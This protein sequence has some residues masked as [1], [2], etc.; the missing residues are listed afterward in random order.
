MR[1]KKF[2]FYKQNFNLICKKFDLIEQVKETIIEI[3][4]NTK[5]VYS[6]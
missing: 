4:Y 3:N 6:L 5:S 1:I 2:V